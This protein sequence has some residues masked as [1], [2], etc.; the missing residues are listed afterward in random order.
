MVKPKM[1]FSKNLSWALWL[2]KVCDAKVGPFVGHESI[3]KDVITLKYLPE[4]EDTKRSV[5]K[6]GFSKE[7]WKEWFTLIVLQ[8]CYDHSLY[9]DK[10][11]E[12]LNNLLEHPLAKELVQIQLEDHKQLT[13]L[14]DLVTPL[15]KEYFNKI[16]L[17]LS[18]ESNAKEYLRFLYEFYAC[19]DRITP[20]YRRL[21][22]SIIDLD[23]ILHVS[24]D[25]V[26]TRTT[27]CIGNMAIRGAKALRRSCDISEDTSEHIET[28]HTEPGFHMYYSVYWMFP[29]GDSED[30]VAEFSRQLN[31]LNIVA[32]YEKRVE[33]DLYS[34]GF[35][36]VSLQAC[37]KLP[38]DLVW[39]P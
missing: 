21:L 14:S 22:R 29:E 19:E 25:I 27:R 6:L 30:F 20:S 32:E 10:D 28:Y 16:I 31:F 12:Y 17:G 35:K 33:V 3:S 7:K 11:S 26:L 1:V 24:L 38:R 5:E 15:Q 39:G 18:D 4:L 36:G 23:S 34:F 13:G 37:R 8:E 9:G 2:L